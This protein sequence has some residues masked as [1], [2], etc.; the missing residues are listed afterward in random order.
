MGQAKNLA[1]LVLISFQKELSKRDV[2]IHYDIEDY[3]QDIENLDKL[4]K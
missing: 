1:G 2:Y 3:Y 4:D